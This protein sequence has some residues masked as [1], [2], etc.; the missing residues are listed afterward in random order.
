[1]QIVGLAFGSGLSD[2]DKTPLVEGRL[3][4]RKAP[5]EVRPWA[6][7]CPPSAV[8]LPPADL[9]ISVP[10]AFQQT[11]PVHWTKSTSLLR[12]LANQAS[13]KSDGR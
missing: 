10:P 6:F 7:R 3:N 9:A 4:P 13:A 8:T 2:T 1:M 11:W 12:S 5:K